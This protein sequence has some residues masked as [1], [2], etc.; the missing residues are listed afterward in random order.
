MKVYNSIVKNII[1]IQKYSEHISKFYS[2][3]YWGNQRSNR[4]SSK[5]MQEILTSRIIEDRDVEIHFSG[6]D[7]KLVT[8]LSGNKIITVGVKFSNRQ[9]KKKHNFTLSVFYILRYCR[10]S[11][12]W[13]P[14]KGTFPVSQRLSESSIGNVLIFV[15]NGDI[16][17]F[18][19]CF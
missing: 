13:W 5:K 18:L 16:I 11:G 7:P 4:A 15:L 19:F 1:L 6:L 17:T 3:H 10:T 9:G 12:P 2:I 14:D 8:I